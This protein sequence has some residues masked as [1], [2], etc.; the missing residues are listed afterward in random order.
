MGLGVEAIMHIA[1]CEGCGKEVQFR[2]YRN[3]WPEGWVQTGMSQWGKT[4]HRRSGFAWWC[5]DCYGAHSYLPRALPRAARR[6]LGLLKSET[7]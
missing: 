7:D 1:K 6:A 2:T 5:P 4:Y 3:N